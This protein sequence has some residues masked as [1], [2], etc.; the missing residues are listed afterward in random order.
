[1]ADR[2]YL[3]RHASALEHA[4]SV[5]I[6]ETLAASP[7]NPV[8]YLAIRVA[9]RGLILQNTSTTPSVTA[10]PDDLFQDL[11]SIVAEL[12][13]MKGELAELQS[14]KSEL[15]DLRARINTPVATATCVAEAEAA[16][17][18]NAEA[19]TVPKAAEAPTHHGS[20]ALEPIT[21]ERAF[22]LIGG[23]K[24]LAEAK[25]LR[26]VQMA[27][28][29][30]S[31]LD[32]ELNHMLPHDYQ[33]RKGFSTTLVN[34]PY[35]SD[36]HMLYTLARPVHQLFKQR[37]QA[38]AARTGGVAH[39]P[40]M[41]GQERAMTKAE[42]KYTDE[43]GGVA[44]YR[45]T[46]LIRGTL[47]YPDIRSMYIALKAAMDEFDGCVH[48]VNDRYE[49]PMDGGYRDLQLVVSIN[50]IMC[51][52][53]VNT[54]PMLQAKETTG[55]RDFEVLRELKAAVTAGSLARCER[56]LR[57]GAA[58]LAAKEA[59]LRDLLQ[60]SE[61]GRLF[62]D[63]AAVGHADILC[64]FLSY[65]AD[66]N[67]TDANGDTAL[68]LAAFG[69]HER[70]I[71]ALVNVGHAD[72]AVVNHK[73]QTALVRA[74]LMLNTQPSESRVRGLM[75]LA[76][77]VA[78][79]YGVTALIAAKEQAQSAIKDMVTPSRPLADAAADGDHRRV[80]DMLRKYA[81]PDS[82][83]ADGTPA[84]V[85]A[86][87]AGSEEVVKT[88][89]QFRA[90][91]DAIDSEGNTS[92]DWLHSAGGQE[93]IVELLSAQGARAPVAVLSKGDAGAFFIKVNMARESFLR[94]AHVNFS[95]MRLDSKDAV[96]LSKLLTTTASITS[97]R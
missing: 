73:Q 48:E 87:M 25:A 5:G 85:A 76:H 52:L 70:S 63:A 42:F 58:N 91:V 86:A 68:H 33:Q 77:V 32:Q 45:I 19:P 36:L 60:R 8:A 66:V 18:G 11:P 27:K 6:T 51:E 59:G 28:V 1:M 10:P 21:Y 34:Q 90:S 88:L 65:G 29:R 47:E 16:G 20:P 26:D 80:L 24:Q 79:Q 94:Q 89:I 81:D 82:K 9:A 35:V 17:M 31:Q 41:K 53:Q 64:L 43:A 62:C 55:H 92:L 95:K 23:D 4:I 22:S 46:D 50:G 37:L 30:D 69:G 39:V 49:M 97:L 14:L 54:K 72:V 75:T 44:W 84:I 96:V 61:A 38:L 7:E 93:A 3:E 71:W 78:K 56:A 2:A 67:A 74:Y 40:T 15:A 83:T 57:W 12:Q 13:S